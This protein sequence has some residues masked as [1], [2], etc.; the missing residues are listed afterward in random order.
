METKIYVLFTIYSVF[1]ISYVECELSSGAA[2]FNAMLIRPKPLPMPMLEPMVSTAFPPCS[3]FLFQCDDGNCIH[4]SNFCNF[5]D[6]CRNGA[7][8]KVNVNQEHIAQEHQ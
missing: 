6:D 7:D 4:Y 1:A 2:L 5:V 3:N 8:E